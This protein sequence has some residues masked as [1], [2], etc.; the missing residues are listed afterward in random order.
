MTTTMASL[1]LPDRQILDPTGLRYREFFVV[2]I[3]LAELAQVLGS[4]P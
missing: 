2:E 4:N 1:E 3:Q